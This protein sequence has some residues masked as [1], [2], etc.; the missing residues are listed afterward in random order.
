MI[1]SGSKHMTTMTWLGEQ[2]ETLEDLVPPNS[3]AIF[4]GIN[5][6]PINVQAGP[7]SSRDTG[8][9]VLEKTQQL[10]HSE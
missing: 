9:E 7:L 2:I 10:P 6:S 1:T 5:P 4:V 8:K 3:K